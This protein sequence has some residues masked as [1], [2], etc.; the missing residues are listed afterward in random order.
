[1]ENQN[2]KQFEKELKETIKGD[3]SFDEFVKGV[4]AT[5]AS[6]F[7]ITPVAVVLPRD[8][9][10]VI[11]ALELARKYKVPIVPRGGGTSLGGQAAGQ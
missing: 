1:M 2:L 11:S 5:D 6:V 9:Q 7:Q 8:D 4:Y 10:D 3:V